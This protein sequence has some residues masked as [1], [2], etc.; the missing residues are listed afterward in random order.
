[1]NFQRF[2][3]CFSRYACF[4][5]EQVSGVFPGFS[6]ANYGEWVRQGYIR[7]LRRGFYAFSDAAVIPG[8]CDYFAGRIYSPS[9]LSCECVMSRCG[10]IPESVVQIT[11]VTTLKTASFSNEFGEFAYRTVKPDLMFGYDVQLVGGGLPFCVAS[12]AKALCD[13]LYLNP[14]YSSREELEGLRLDEDAMRDLLSDGSLLAV[15]AR[16]SSRSLS[17]RVSIV[18]EMFKP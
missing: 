15:A 18:K 2:R 4:S 5:V 17:A 9:Y 10:L 16:F 3:T 11:S 12:P 13:F 8:I 1:M 7:R 6:R 14:Q